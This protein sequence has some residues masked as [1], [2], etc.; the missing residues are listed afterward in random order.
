M[1]GK[2]SKKQGK[3]QGYKDPADEKGKNSVG[4]RLWGKLRLTQLL[5]KS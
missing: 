4:K 1:D 3:G 5:E 2:E